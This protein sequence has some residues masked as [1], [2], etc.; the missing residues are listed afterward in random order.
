MSI[1]INTTPKDPAANSYASLVEA[2]TWMA[3]RLYT[4]VWDAATDD[5]KSKALIWATALLDAS[6]DW[7]G[8][9]RTITQVLKWPRSGVRAEIDGPWYDYDT[10]PDILKQITT[11]FAALLL[12]RDRTVEPGLLGK[13]FKEASAGSLRIVVDDLQVLNFIPDY[14]LTRCK[15]LGQ[16]AEVRRSGG[17][18]IVKLSRA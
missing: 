4:D 18:K 6:M 8:T 9:R 10:I 16:V 11:E 1:V 7:F 5:N 14:I 15:F 17:A 12:S 2:N 3:N 13:G